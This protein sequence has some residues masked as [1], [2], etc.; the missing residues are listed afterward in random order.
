MATILSTTARIWHHII[1][2]LLL[3]AGSSGDRISLHCIERLDRA[4][5]ETA[6]KSCAFS[7]QF[8]ARHLPAKS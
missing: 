6:E 1:A 5:A 7:K 3:L 8:F 2:G 4:G